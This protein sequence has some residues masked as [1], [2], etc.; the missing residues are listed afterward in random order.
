MESEKF[1]RILRETAI[2]YR[3]E[4]LQP[5]IVPQARILDSLEKS[6]RFVLEPYAERL[7][8]RLC[9]DERL[10]RRLWHGLEF[11]IMGEVQDAISRGVTVEHSHVTFDVTP[12]A[13]DFHLAS[14]VNSLA[15]PGRSLGFQVNDFS[16]SP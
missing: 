8:A 16:T 1:E 13:A 12:E 3:N 9:E 5:V 15:E 6:I 7:A 2:A 10:V 11:Y 14:F 4:E